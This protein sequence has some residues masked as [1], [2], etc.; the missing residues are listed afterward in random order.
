MGHLLEE[1]LEHYGLF[2]VF[3][4][5]I[6][7]GDVILVLA[8]VVSHLG[9]FTPFEAFVAS[10]SGL[11]IGDC[12]WYYVGRSLSTKVQNSSLYRRMWPRIQ[13]LSGKWGVWEILAARFVYGS[14]TASMIFWGV[15]KLKLLQFVCIDLIGC[16]LWTTLLITLGFYLS[17]SAET[18]IGEVKRIEVWLLGAFIFAVSIFL[19]LRV[20]VHQHFRKIE[21]RG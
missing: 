14:R 10:W 19:C 6:F 9:F 11:L 17:R 8:G 3:F 2:A 20:V 16:T 12:G 13:F 21:L 1:I 15:Q 5:S 7:E 18:L 4:I